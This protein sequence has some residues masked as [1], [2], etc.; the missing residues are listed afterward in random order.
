MAGLNPWDSTTCE[1]IR[2]TGYIGSVWGADFVVSDLFELELCPPHPD[3]YTVSNWL[4]Q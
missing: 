3:S 1:E 4:D 2:K